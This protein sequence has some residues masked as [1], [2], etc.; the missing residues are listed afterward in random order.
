MPLTFW[1]VFTTLFELTLSK[2]REHGK[3]RTLH[4]RGNVK[5]NHTLGEPRHRL[6]PLGNLERKTLLAFLFWRG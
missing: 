3:F 2:I 4:A 6:A 5:L 1:S